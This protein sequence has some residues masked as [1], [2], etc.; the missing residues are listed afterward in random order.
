MGK[1]APSVPNRVKRRPHGLRLLW[2]RVSPAVRGRDADGHL[3]PGAL[4]HA[5]HLELGVQVEAVAALALHQRGA[6]AQHALQPLLEGA[7]Q[8]LLRGL[9]R[10]LH[11]EVDP[12]AGLVDFHV[13]GS[14]QLNNAQ[15]TIRQLANAGRWQAALQNL[16]AVG[17]DGEGYSKTICNLYARALANQKGGGARNSQGNTGMAEMGG[18]VVEASRLRSAAIYHRV[19]KYFSSLTTQSTPVCTS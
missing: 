17:R 13:R 6:R 12:P 4:D 7:E 10:A 14:C 19:Q 16:P 2:H 3:P 5:E 18:D 8:L 15:L 11:G 1:A 9:A